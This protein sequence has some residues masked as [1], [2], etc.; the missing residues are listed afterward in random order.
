MWRSKKFIIVAVLTAVVLAGSIGGVVLTNDDE[1]QPRARHEALLDRVCEIYE[2]N[3]GIAIDA[4]ELQKAY[5]E[6]QSEM[7]AAVMEDRLAKM[8][9]S[10]VI[11]ETQAQELQ[12]WWESRPEDVPFGP[13]LRGPGG[14]RG[15][16]GMHGFGG[17][18][19]PAAAL[20]E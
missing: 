18:F 19:G 6:A 5:A 7:Q 4:D 10:G 9:E 2:E 20:A 12:E 14:F 8:V 17:M 1:N 3:T 16:G 11:D 15:M 13:G